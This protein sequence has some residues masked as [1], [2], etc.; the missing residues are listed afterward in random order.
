MCPFFQKSHYFSLPILNYSCQFFAKSYCFKHVQN[1]M[2]S[3]HKEDKKA[4]FGLKNWELKGLNFLVLSKKNGKFVYF[5]FYFLVCQC[6]VIFITGS[7]ALFAVYVVFCIVPHIKLVYTVFIFV[8]SRT[9]T[10]LSKNFGKFF[11]I[12]IFFHLQWKMS[13]K[14]YGIPCN[15]SGYALGICQ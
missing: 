12:V 11:N 6:K 10:K 13:V 9:Q 2:I 5:I 4:N 15:F 8:N 14:F 1:L 7:G 3:H